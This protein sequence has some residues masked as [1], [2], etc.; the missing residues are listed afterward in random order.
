MTGNS[1]VCEVNCTIASFVLVLFL[2]WYCILF[3][4]IYHYWRYTYWYGHNGHVSKSNKWSE[5]AL[6]VGNYYQRICL[7]VL[8]T[9]WT[10]IVIKCSL[11]FADLNSDF[12][13]LPFDK[14]PVPIIMACPWKSNEYW[15]RSMWR[16]NCKKVE[17][18]KWF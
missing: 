3:D 5:R 6:F 17:Y 8:K 4:Q 7:L 14:L 10:I 12:C 2:F 16:L 15:N 13:W 18:E 9:S 11:V 1:S